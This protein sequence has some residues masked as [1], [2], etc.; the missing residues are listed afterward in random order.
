MLE[1]TNTML[2][3]VFTGIGS[4]IFSIVVYFYKNWRKTVNK[5]KQIY[6]NYLWW[7]QLNNEIIKSR[8]KT[9]IKEHKKRGGLPQQSFQTFCFYTNKLMKTT[10][11]FGIFI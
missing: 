4:A 2:E 9:V 6:Q 5:D 8:I 11:Y 1:E 10:K 3:I 7:L